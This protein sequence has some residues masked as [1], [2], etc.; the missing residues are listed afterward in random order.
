[1]QQPAVATACA[2]ISPAPSVQLRDAYGNDNQGSE[3]VSVWLAGNPASGTLSGQTVVAAQNGRATFDDLWI[4]RAGDGY[5]LYA[6]AQASGASALSEPFR[7]SAGPPTHA[8]VLDQPMRARSRVPLAPAPAAMLLDGCENPA[9]SA[10]TVTTLSIASNPGAASLLGTTEVAASG[11][12]VAFPGVSVDRPGSGYQL[13]IGAPGVAPATTGPFDV[14]PG[15]ASRYGVAGPTA[16]Q[17]G[18]AASYDVSA[19]D[20]NGDVAWDY[21][22][23]AT[24]QT[25]D[26]AATAPGAVTFTAGH[27]AGVPI[28]FRTAGPQRL[29]LWDQADASITGS[30]AVFVDGQASP[31]LPPPSPPPEQHAKGGCGCGTGGA[32]GG[33]ALLALAL[34]L[35]PR[36]R[37]R[38]R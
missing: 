16:P 10:T 12:M 33:A 4:D 28:T 21:T 1:M 27:A 9:V 35:R 17:S 22:G 37:G 15:T 13:A 25:S 8:L 23:T 2:A 5:S 32:E 19:L 7:V 18:A 30:V 24:V 11:G 14:F 36:R 6:S 29:A 26:P 34:A 3:L 20:A 31:D 38:A